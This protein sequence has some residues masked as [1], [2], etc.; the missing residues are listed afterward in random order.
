MNRKRCIAA[1]LVLIIMFVACGAKHG[2]RG[3]KPA[4]RPSW[5]DAEA[6]KAIETMA[7]QYRKKGDPFWD[8][9]AYVWENGW[10]WPETAGIS[11]KNIKLLKEMF[12]KGDDATKEI[13][14]RVIYM[15]IPSKELEKGDPK[16]MA[17]LVRLDTDLRERRANVPPPTFQ[18]EY[19]EEQ[20]APPQ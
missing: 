3:A 9:R 1:L 19:I 8:E 11:K 12:Y 14:L 10:V 4:K 7:E 18:H 17:D 6:R 16:F 13:V 2:P 20:G 15:N 5:S